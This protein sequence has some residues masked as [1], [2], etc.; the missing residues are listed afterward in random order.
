MFEIIFISM[1]NADIFLLNMN[2]QKSQPKFRISGP[3]W[4]I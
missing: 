4:N 1:I 2:T 3:K